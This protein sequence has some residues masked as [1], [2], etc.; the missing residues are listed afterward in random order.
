MVNKLFTVVSLR[1]KRNSRAGPLILE[2]ERE[3][4]EYSGSDLKYSIAKFE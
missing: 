2:P 4:C 3:G 1:M